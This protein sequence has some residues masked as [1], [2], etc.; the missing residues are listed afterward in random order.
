MASSGRGSF[1]DGGKLV[2]TKSLKVAAAAAATAFLTWKAVEAAKRSCRQKELMKLAAKKR[3][4]RDA[5]KHEELLK[6]M[7]KT[8]DEQ[9]KRELILVSLTAKELRE[10]MARRVVTCEEVTLAFCRRA[11]TFG[12]FRGKPGECINCVTEE[13]YDEALRLAREIDR[14]PDEDWKNIEKYPLLGIPIS[15]KDQLNQK[16]FDST[17]GSATRCF[18]W[19]EA[20]CPEDGLLVQI[21]KEAGAVVFV[22]SITQQA[23][24][25]PE[26]AN[27]VWGTGCNAYDVARTCGGSSGG[28]AGLLGARCSALG[29]GTDIG[30]SVRIP[31]HFNGLYGL[32]PTAE[33]MSKKGISMP[34]K[35]E[36]NGQTTIKSTAGPLGHCVEDLVSVMRAWWRASMWEADVT[37]PRM[38]FDEEIYS[39]RT[40]PS[41]SQ[42]KK[43]LRQLR[44]AYMKT[45]GWFQPCSAITRAVEEAATGLRNAGHIVSELKLPKAID[46]E[47]CAQLYLGVMAADGNFKAFCDGLEG[48]RLHP[49]YNSLKVLADFPNFLR[50]PVQGLL[51]LMKETRKQKL[52]GMSRNGG[53]SVRQYWEILAD[54]EAYRSSWANLFAEQ[55]FDVLL[56]PG[57]ALPALKHGESKNLNQACS[58][59]FLLNLLGWPAGT[60]PIT[61]VQSDEQSYPMEALPVD[62]RD[63][64]AKLANA[65]MQG[66][67]GLPVG[68]QLTAPPYQDEL[69]L[70]AMR[71]LEG[72]CP[73][74]GRSSWAN[75]VA[76]KTV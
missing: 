70:Y 3:A 75:K 39:G 5:K 41:Q 25:L 76:P 63:S 22:R 29:I 10:R 19:G 16:G 48:E 32:K 24:M 38:R 60:C 68:V 20:G 51:G 7:E 12:A 45:D 36:R 58:Y 69:V 26:S 30:G 21:L 33:R 18:R 72:A 59:T 34:R 47:V 37:V 53:W 42:N 44:V 9:Q 65:S 73:F 57:L 74:V 55:N 43:G 50:P 35:L 13:N 2:D 71:E 17:M 31:A 11:Y 66:S 56:L 64:I 1:N 46:G 54:I 27:N 61:Q 40:N 4:M 14:R 8:S 67:A 23:L 15:V 52:F 28:E 62:Q 6:A 49:M